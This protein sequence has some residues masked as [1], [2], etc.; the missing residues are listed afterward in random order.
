M[1]Q[2]YVLGGEVDE[3]KLT[4]QPVELLWKLYSAHLSIQEFKSFAGVLTTLSPTV[5]RT[6]LQNL[7]NVYTSGPR[8]TSYN[9]PFDDGQSRNNVEVGPITSVVVTEIG[10]VLVG[11]GVLFV[12]EEDDDEAEVIVLEEVSFDGWPV[13][14]EELPL[15]L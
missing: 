12:F 7:R 1:E 3:R 10:C 9:V 13:V 4:Y 5:T 8:V 11:V 14:V 6:V 2:R 15:D